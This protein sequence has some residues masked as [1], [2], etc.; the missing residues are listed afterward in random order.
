MYI[1]RKYIFQNSIEIE[2]LHTHKYHKK[3]QKRNC[4]TNPTPEKMQEYNRIRQIDHLRRLIKL[5]MPGGY[6][7]VLTYDK[8][9]RPDKALAK[10][11][12]NNFMARIK[13]H[14]SKSGQEIKYIT[15]TEYENK[16]IHHHVVINDIDGIISLVKQQWWYG[17]PNFTPLADGEDVRTLAEYLIKETDKTFRLDDVHGT[18]YSRSR[19]LV[20][21]TCTEKVIGADSFRKEPKAPDGYVL[22]RDSFVYGVSDTGYEYQKYELKKITPEFNKKS[23][24]MLRSL[25]MERKNKNGKLRSS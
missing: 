3:G 18:R 25:E 14:L 10:K 1:L 19:N 22:N 23:R 13:Y 24:A 2:K 4:K 11:Q 16:A 15:T 6:H 21:P 7:M 17:T 12:F 20:E 8:N 9:N 5:N